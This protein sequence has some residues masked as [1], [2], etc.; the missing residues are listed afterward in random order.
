MKFYDCATAPSPRRVRIF[1]AEK[2][3]E[4]K[5]IQVDLASGEHFSEAFKAINPLSQVPVLE[6]ADG[7]HLSPIMAIFCSLEEVDPENPFVGRA[8]WERGHVETTKQQQHGN[9]M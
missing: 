3:I 9:G 7:T 5:T 6:L 4:I 1:M 8:P 2:N